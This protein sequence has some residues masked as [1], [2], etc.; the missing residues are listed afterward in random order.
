MGVVAC[1]QRDALTGAATNGWQ[2]NRRSATEKGGGDLK[3][4]RHV[5]VVMVVL[6]GLRLRLWIGGK[7]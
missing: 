1:L 6:D 2:L 4:S 7:E 3:G 5:V